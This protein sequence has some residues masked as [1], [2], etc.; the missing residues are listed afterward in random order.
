MPNVG[1]EL[2]TL[3]SSVA[4]FTDWASQVP[5]QKIFKRK[6]NS[7][8]TCWFWFLSCTQI[9]LG[10]CLVRS[11]VS[12]VASFYFH[13]TNIPLHPQLCYMPW[14]FR[15]EGQVE[16]CSCMWFFFNVYFW[17]KERAWVGEGERA[18][19]RRGRPESEAGSRLWAVGTEPDTGLKLMSWSWCFMTWAEV[20]CLSD[21]ATQVPQI[22]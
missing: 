9:I 15:R 12:P 20:R 22:V 16:M 18:G 1:L 7:V 5:Q 14:Q 6:M 10:R 2:Q 8:G 11:W 19:P 4:C 13:P 21:W 3:R 17:R